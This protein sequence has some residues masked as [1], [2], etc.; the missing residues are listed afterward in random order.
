MLVSKGQITQPKAMAL[1]LVV[2]HL[3]GSKELV[4]ILHNLGHCASCDSLRNYEASL[5]LHT[6]SNQGNVLDIFQY[7]QP[8]VM[9]WDNI[10]FSEATRTGLNITH[11]TNEILLQL[12][13]QKPCT[14]SIKQ[15]Q[16]CG[17]V[18]ALSPTTEIINFLPSHSRSNP[19]HLKNATFSDEVI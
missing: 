2:K 13:V 16:P 12:S 17:R 6:L 19:A 4:N 14:N 7:G 9:V 11:Y 15:M 3:T 5:G 1:H 8:I 10:D 18:K